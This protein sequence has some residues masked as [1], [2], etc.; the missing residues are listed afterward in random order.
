[1]PLQAGEIR[2]LKILNTPQV[3]GSCAIEITLLR[4]NLEHCVDYIAVS[5][6]WG[7]SKPNKMLETDDGTLILI[8][9]NLWDFLS[10]QSKELA[11]KLLWIDQIC[12]NQMDLSERAC[13][14]RIMSRI[15]ENATET[16]IWLGNEDD[17]TEHAFQRIQHFANLPE[18]TVDI[19]RVGT[20]SYPPDRAFVNGHGKSLRNILGRSWFS[21]LWALQEAVL[22]KSPKFLCGTK[23]SSWDDLVTA[24]ANLS[25][26][27][28]TTFND[29]IHTMDFLRN[30]RQE[31]GQ[32][33]LLS[34]L[35]ETYLSFKCSDPRDKVYALLSMQSSISDLPIDYT[36]KIEDVYIATAQALVRSTSSLDLLG[37][38]DNS[39][40]LHLPEKPVLPSWVPD[41][42][43]MSWA[44]PFLDK[45][46]FQ[47]CKDFTTLRH[48][49]SIS[50]SL[51]ADGRIIDRVYQAENV[52]D[53]DVLSKSDENLDAAQAFLQ[54]IPN[55]IYHGIPGTNYIL[56]KRFEALIV[57]TILVGHYTL[58]NG[59]LLHIDWTNEERIWKLLNGKGLGP[60]DE[61]D[62][63]SL[64]FEVRWMCRR[65]TILALEEHTLGLG[66]PN[67][68]PGDV[69]CI[70]HGSKL[71]I[72]LRRQGDR[73]RL[74]G[75]CY[76]DGIMFGEAV[77]WAED[78]ADS[79]EII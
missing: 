10:A 69:I 3:H 39:D 22:S 36:A 72:V 62:A 16:I 60:N 6:A 7:A 66:P 52:S 30:K 63:R 9:S 23:S 45:F 2:L 51:K 25:L 64:W 28:D 53:V 57:R 1:L 4:H 19:L 73:W 61:F 35:V 37:A 27:F 50:T 67:T 75:Q 44:N 40:L 5:Y 41:W 38:V 71:P 21:R 49:E 77:T 48:S 59:P 76:V 13:Q 20:L 56:P 70:L 17:D 78:D 18:E 8:T 12:I 74:I 55:K 15:F 11:G 14:V 26:V 24:F 31:G 54:N 43:G 47:A 46:H 29:T 65:R 32:T 79:F 34:L 58:D 42:R 33:S 68:E